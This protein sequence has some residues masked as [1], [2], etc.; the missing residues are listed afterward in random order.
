MQAKANGE[1]ERKREERG[2]G[3]RVMR[4]ER[5]CKTKEREEDE[6]EGGMVRMRQPSWHRVRD[7]KAE[8][9]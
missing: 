2:E 8:M 7:R 9:H 1:G 3:E 6:E 5:V 4:T